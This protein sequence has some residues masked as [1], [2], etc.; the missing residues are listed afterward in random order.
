MNEYSGT[1]RFG[2]FAAHFDIDLRNTPVIRKQRE[3]F[4]EQGFVLGFIGWTVTARA[5]IL[6]DAPGAA[7]PPPNAQGNTPPPDQQ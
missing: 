6:R 4:I 3:R 1:E 5:E 2:S 7:I